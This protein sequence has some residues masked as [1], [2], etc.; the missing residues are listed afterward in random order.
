MRYLWI[1]SWVGCRAG[2]DGVEKRKAFFFLPGLK[3]RIFGRSAITI[4]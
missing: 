3:L 2:L 1:R 4:S